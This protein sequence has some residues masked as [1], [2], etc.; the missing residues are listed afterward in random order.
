MNPAK[1][2]RRRRPLISEGRGARRDMPSGEG[3]SAN[4]H[5]NRKLDDVAHRSRR[6]W[7]PRG[8]DPDLSDDGFLVDPESK[9]AQIRGSA[10]LPFQAFADKP[11]L[12]L[13]GEPGIG[14]T[15]A[16]EA[17]CARVKS[18]LSGTSGRVFWVDLGLYGSGA[19]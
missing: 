6:F 15:T 10:A 12:I 8:T 4:D 2:S 7:V 14:K 11:V 16:L 13:L 3:S 18:A 9:R 1:G 17:E 19:L 5:L